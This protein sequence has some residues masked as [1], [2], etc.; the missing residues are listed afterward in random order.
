MEPC[1]NRIGD[2]TC[3][4]MLYGYGVY[5]GVMV[6]ISKNQQENQENIKP[7]RESGKNKTGKKLRENG[8]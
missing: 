2:A 8:C 1:D 3:A 4:I 5:A 7:S 6:R